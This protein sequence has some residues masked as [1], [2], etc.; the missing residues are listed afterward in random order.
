MLALTDMDLRQVISA[1]FNKDNIEETILSI[2]EQV[3][4]ED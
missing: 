4:M 3:Q 1:P 2:K